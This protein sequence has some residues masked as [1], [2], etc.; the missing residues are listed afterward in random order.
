MTREIP[1][2]CSDYSVDGL[3]LSFLDSE[4]TK[5][6]LHFSHANGFPV[7]MYLPWMT[8][9]TRDFRV[10][11]LSLRGQDG[12]SEGISN[13][14]RVALDLAGFLETRDVGPVIGVGHSIGAVATM[15]C[16]AR[17][18]DL[19][20]RIVLLDPPLFPRRWVALFRWVKLFG[21]KKRFPPAV[22]ARRRRNGWPDRQEALDYFRG[23]AMFEGWKEEYLHAYVT[24]GLRPDPDRGT[25]LICP[26]EAE[27]RGFESYPTDIW[28]WPRKLRTPTLLVRGGESKVLTAAACENFCRLCPQAKTA[29]VEGAGHFIP[30]QRPEETIRLIKDSARPAIRI[31]PESVSFGRFASR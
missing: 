27:A 30:M 19:F 1:F 25:V 8:E 5:P 3:A 7:S 10:M 12:L 4:G 11:G 13:W 26:P 9:L 21:Q 14:H 24:Y 15:L 17:R 16:A 18:P 2:E 22:R 29:V 28:S 23:K 20:S 31:R 6:P